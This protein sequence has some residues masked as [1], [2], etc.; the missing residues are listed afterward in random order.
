MTVQ[1]ILTAAS[2]LSYEERLQVAIR[3]LESLTQA[4]P[5]PTRRRFPVPALAGKAKTL[6]DIVSPM[7]DEGDWECLK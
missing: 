4:N 1:D 3:L 6:G 7:V 5:Q 2:E